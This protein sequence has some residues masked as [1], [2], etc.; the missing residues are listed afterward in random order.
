MDQALRQFGY[1]SAQPEIF[2][3]KGG[4]SPAAW[5][6]ELKAKLKQNV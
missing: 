1:E 5:I 4:M 3:V 6:E 2:A